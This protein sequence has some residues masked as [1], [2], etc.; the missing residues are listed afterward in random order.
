MSAL[1]AGFG[2]AISA[3]LVP[4][5]APVIE[6]SPLR[7][8]NAVTTVIHLEADWLTL[9]QWSGFES[10]WSDLASWYFDIHGNALPYKVTV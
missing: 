4:P 6:L 2:T 10:N 8:T 1:L 7:Q 5:S 3:A 9:G